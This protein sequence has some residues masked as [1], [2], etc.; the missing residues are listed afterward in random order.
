MNAGERLK[1]LTDLSAGFCGWSLPTEELVALVR[2]H[3]AIS[4]RDGH[5]S[6]R[7]AATSAERWRA[8]PWYRR[9]MHA[10]PPAP[11]PVPTQQQLVESW[12]LHFERFGEWMANRATSRFYSDAFQKEMVAC[13]AL[14]LA[15]RA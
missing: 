5:A 14:V 12:A 10:Q 9:W 2:E 8:L 4:V 1:A 7:D 3:V 13:K 11:M 6:A 15:L